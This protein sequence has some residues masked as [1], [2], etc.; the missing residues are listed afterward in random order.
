MQEQYRHDQQTAA[1]TGRLNADQDVEDILKLALAKTGSEE[2]ALRARLELSAR[3]LGI[4]PEALAEAEAEHFRMKALAAE[5]A[6]LNRKNRS[7]FYGHLFTYLAVCTF[8][9]VV[10]MMASPQTPWVVFVILGWGVS[11]GG[12]AWEA[13]VAKSRRDRKSQKNETSPPL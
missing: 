11:V 8:L 13:F 1:P 12:H 7:E 3:E 6:D 9:V 4:S 5:T 10:N 2:A